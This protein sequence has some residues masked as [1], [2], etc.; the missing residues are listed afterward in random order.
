VSKPVNAATTI[1]LTVFAATSAC[2]Q[3]VYFVQERWIRERYEAR[4]ADEHPG[5]K[6][7]QDKKP[8]KGHGDD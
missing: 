8:K 2:G 3:P 7:K 1:A 5:R 6:G 4:D